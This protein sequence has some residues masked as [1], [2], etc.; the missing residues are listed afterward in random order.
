MTSVQVPR[1]GS[2]RVGAVKPR[3]L[4]RRAGAP[5]RQSTSWTSDAA[6]QLG[7]TMRNGKT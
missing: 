6:P 2:S 4:H 7:H 3:R 1:A 5:S